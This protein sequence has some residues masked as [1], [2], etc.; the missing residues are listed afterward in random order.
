LWAS[1]Q[2]TP[3]SLGVRPVV[4]CRFRF[5]LSGAEVATAQ[6]LV[7]LTGRLVVG[8]ANPADIAIYDP[9]RPRHA[10]LLSSFSPSLAVSDF[11]QWEQDQ[12]KAERFF[13]DLW[14]SVGPDYPRE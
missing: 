11:R 2:A 4:A 12:H 7:D 10:L 5:E 1:G 14:A 13:A 6:A 9:R 3:A 8:K